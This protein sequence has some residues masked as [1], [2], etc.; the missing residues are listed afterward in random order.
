MCGIAG[1]ISIRNEKSY[2]REVNKMLDVINHRGPDGRG[3][4]EH[5][6][7]SLGHVRLSIIDLQ[8]SANQPLLT[9]DENYA[10][11][12]NGEI[13]N[14][15]ELRASLSSSYSFKTRSDTEVIL[16]LYQ[17]KGSKALS[18]LNGMFSFVIYDKI[19]QKIFGARDRFGI[20]PFYYF[21][22]EQYFI[23]C[24]EIKGILKSGLVKPELNE[25][26]LYDFV[27][28]N[29]TDHAAETC[30]ENILNLKPGY[31]I[32]I[33]LNSREIALTQ[34]YYLPEV[35]ERK[36]SFED[37][38]RILRKKLEETTRLHLV[39]DVEVGIALSGGIDSSTLLS[40]MREQ[41]KND[42][43]YAFSAVYDKNWE[44]DETIYVEAVSAAK[45]T[46]TYYAYPTAQTLLD[47]F[48]DLIYQQE[49][50]YMSASV[51]A[52]WCVYKK[53]R[54][55]NIKVLLNGQGADEMFSYDYMAAFY[56]YELFRELKWS[57][58][59]KEIFLFTQKQ[60][61]SRFT[62]QLF[63][64]MLAPAFAKQ[65][66]ISLYNPLVNEEFK[67]QFKEKSFFMEFF[68]SPTLNHNV[69]NH[70]LMKLHHQLRIEDKN[71]MKFGVEVRVP[72]LE[73]QLLDF[74]MNI[75][76]EYKIR[77]GEVKYVLKHA[78]KDILPEIIFKRNNKVGF[79]APMDRWMKEKIF[80]DKLGDMIHSSNQN[81]KNY[82]NLNYVRKCFEEHIKGR[83]NH[84][85]TLWKYMY[86][87]RWY[88]LF[89]E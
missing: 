81:M 76:S 6:K 59:I 64:F 65:R 69:R 48:D 28:F 74:V 44:K 24:S 10:I 63:A 34:W 47:E 21:L 67:K 84:S 57:K 88:Q 89:F 85:V 83:K 87:T 9:N 62:L 40:L 72:Y 68:N 4:Y 14:Y 42:K 75:P 19:N 27:V 37:S 38:T 2:Y 16:A 30:F 66:L 49:E 46:Q 26:M 52:S 3:Y 79:E 32:E 77:N 51:Y 55:H 56:F 33:D 8:E 7:V 11:V 54:E 39:S 15:R 61:S 17:L 45:N 86:L 18:E 71:S 50:P 70:F 31:Q 12:F 13:F 1:I 20:K 43:I 82:L 22:N 53:S 80:Y 41:K 36:E 29:R 35:K 58:L 73:H 5:Q 23:F 25:N 78:V 60:F